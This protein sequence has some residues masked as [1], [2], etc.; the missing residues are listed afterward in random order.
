MGIRKTAMATAAGVFH[1]I[2]ALITAII[3]I[4]RTCGIWMRRRAQ[5]E[6]MVMVGAMALDLGR[7][8]GRGR[9]QAMTTSITPMPRVERRRILS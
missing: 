1:R 5:R 2:Q 6:V 8:R 3:K 7:G 9:G 4:I